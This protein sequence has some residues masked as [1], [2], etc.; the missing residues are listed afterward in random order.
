MSNQFKR[1]TISEEIQEIN[2]IQQKIDESGAQWTAGHTSVSRLSPYEKQRMRGT[3]IK[4]PSPDDIIISRPYGVADDPE[5]FDWRD[6][7][8][9]NWMT[10]VRNQGACGS[11]WAFSVL[12]AVEACI[13][14]Y[15]GEPNP[16]YDLSEQHLV[17]E[18][19]DTGDCG[20]GYLDGALDYIRDYG[21]PPESCFPYQAKNSVCTPCD[22]WE[23][24]AQ[25]IGSYVFVEP[26][27]DS[28][29]WALQNYGPM[30][31]YLQ[32]PDDWY[33][34]AGGVYEPVLTST[35]GAAGHGVVLCGWND[36]DDCW[37]I[38]NSWGTGWGESGYGRVKY[39]NLEKYNYDIAIIV[40]PCSTPTCSIEILKQP[41]K[42]V[43]VSS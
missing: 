19:C 5:S 18:C 13:N 39:G 4:H 33:F 32:V 26:T 17:S 9:S 16:D 1:L 8:G 21:V 29:K 30:S 15:N 27:K 12:G 10:P 3:F 23:D 37:I 35:I 11:C 41:C 22:S 34:Y 31:V 36:S 14:I 6:V 25:T 28:F 40:E 2:A 43:V 38:K 7:D 24:I 42:T 20:G